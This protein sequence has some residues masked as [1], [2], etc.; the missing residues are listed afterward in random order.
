L[1]GIASVVNVYLSVR[2]EREEVV[3]ALLQVV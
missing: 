3:G 1:A 2:R